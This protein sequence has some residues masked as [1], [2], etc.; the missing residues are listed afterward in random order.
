MN[1]VN[2]H[3]LGL[4]I[5]GAVLLL[6]AWNDMTQRKIPNTLLL[7]AS[8]WAL[9][10]S[11]TAAGV[12]LSA[13]LIGGV[14]ALGVF[15]GFYVTGAMGAGDVKLM[16]VVG[17]FLGQSD[18]L[19]LCMSVLIAGGLQSVIWAVWTSR[20]REVLSSTWQ[21]LSHSMFSLAGGT[22]PVQA[23]PVTL[24]GSMPYALAI[25][26]GTGAHLLLKFW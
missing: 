7:V 3:S 11:T 26:A 24:H 9:L 21:T 22:W 16:G 19:S 14:V 4:W 12:G 20:L 17:L 1:T 25:A 6:A 10:W 5:L 13:A 18:V 8:V 15:L 23:E 2:S